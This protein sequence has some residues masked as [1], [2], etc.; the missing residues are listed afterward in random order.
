MK[1]YIQYLI[2]D[3]VTAVSH[4]DTTIHIALSHRKSHKSE[5][6][7]NKHFTQKICKYSK[8]NS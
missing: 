4:L 3:T 7:H 2:I 6:R 8:T 5:I 1:Q